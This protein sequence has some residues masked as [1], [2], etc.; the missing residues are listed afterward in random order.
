VS[1]QHRLRL[2]A[3]PGWSWNANDAK[4]EEGFR[5]LKE[6]VDREGHAYVPSTFVSADG[7]RLGSWITDQRTRKDD[8]S[9]ERR[10]RLEALS[11]WFWNSNEAKWE[12]GFRHLKEFVNREG[13]A[14]VPKDYVTADG[15]QLGKWVARQQSCRD[16]MSPERKA[17]LEVF[18]T[19]SWTENTFDKWL[20]DCFSP[21]LAAGSS[22]A[23]GDAYGS[24]KTFVEAHGE[25]AVSV[26]RFSQRLEARGYERWKT[27][28]NRRIRR[29]PGIESKTTS[30]NTFDKWIEDC[31]SPSLAA[32]SSV[33]VGDAY[34]SYKAF[35]EAHGEGA[36]SVKRFSQWLIARGYE[37]WKTSSN[38]RIRHGPSI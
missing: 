1:H 34:G 19:L 22:V 38:R 2:E 27:S 30:E 23:V 15:Y 31:F 4:W 29:G 5:H 28:S 25:G 6:F 26:K 17:R 7:Y 8:I 18:L 13:H 20:E 21:S 24:Y 9:P 11:G 12:E 33:A 35:V 36:V 10:V 3:L 32:G 16:D 14:R 37:R